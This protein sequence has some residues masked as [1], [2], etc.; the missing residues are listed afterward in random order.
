[1]TLQEALQYASPE[2]RAYHEKHSDK[3]I[4]MMPNYRDWKVGQILW[5]SY[6]GKANNLITKINRKDISGDDV[7]YYL[8]EKG[9]EEYS[10]LRLIQRYS[11]PLF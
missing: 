7:I 2:V 6:D 10:S 4:K 9:T 3:T 11:I 1:M 8:S 5:N